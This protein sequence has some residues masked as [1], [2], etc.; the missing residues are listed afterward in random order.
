MG[1]SLPSPSDQPVLVLP[2]L[3]H[4]RTAGQHG[5]SMTSHACSGCTLC[6]P[7]K[8]AV[9]YLPI[10]STNCCDSECRIPLWLKNATERAAEQ[11]LTARHEGCVWQTDLRTD[12]CCNTIL[13]A[14]GWDGMG[15]ARPWA[16]TAAPGSTAP[17]GDRARLAAAG[18]RR[19]RPH[20]L[21]FTPTFFVA[22]REKRGDSCD[23]S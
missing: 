11:A 20:A 9:N 19:G 14:M 23:S 16:E 17:A 22:L 21:T 10:C 15:W 1:T 5:S 13:V 4:A 8:G 12:C 6:L 2:P 18:V 7:L 3:L